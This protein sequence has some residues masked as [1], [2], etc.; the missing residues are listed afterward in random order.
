MDRMKKGFLS[1]FMVMA[2]VIV[3]AGNYERNVYA[4]GNANIE[5]T[6]AEGSVG[7][8]VTITVKVTTDVDGM[9]HLAISYDTNYLEYLSGG[10]NSGVAGQVV[11]IIDDI[12]AGTPAETQCRR[13]HRRDMRHLQPRRH[14]PH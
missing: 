13:H 2:L 4:V 6:S 12:K 9:A 5:V 11:D 3:F 1:L 7:D 8:T 10:A 14:R